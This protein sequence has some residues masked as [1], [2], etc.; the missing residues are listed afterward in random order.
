MVHASCHIVPQQVALGVG[1]RDWHIVRV[2]RCGERRTIQNMQ[3]WD[4]GSQPMSKHLYDDLHG[5]W[6]Q[7]ILDTNCPYLSSP[8]LHCDNGCTRRSRRS[9]I[10]IPSGNHIAA[11]QEYGGARSKR[12]KWYVFT[13]YYLLPAATTEL[14]VLIDQGDEFMSTNV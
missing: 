6:L 8:P 3:Q 14:R 10:L 4:Q 12:L 5:G 7:Q 1:K 13:A 9:L 2:N 11:I